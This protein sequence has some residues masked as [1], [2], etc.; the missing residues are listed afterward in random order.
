MLVRG[1]SI[2]LISAASIPVSFDSFQQVKLCIIMKRQYH[3][4]D[5]LQLARLKSMGTTHRKGV[6]QNSS[7]LVMIKKQQDK[8]LESK[9]KKDADRASLKSHHCH[10]HCTC[11]VVRDMMIMT[12]TMRRYQL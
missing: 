7:A 2:S 3:D 10:F 12:M 6:E 9:A 5:V 4:Q 1:L 11:T 8:L